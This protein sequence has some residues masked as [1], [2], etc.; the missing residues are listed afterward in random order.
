MRRNVKI[1]Y[2][3]LYQR[4]SELMNM[5]LYRANLITK[6]YSQIL[7]DKVKDGYNI[8]IPGLFDVVYIGK[9]VYISEVQTFTFEEQYKAVAKELNMDDIEVRKALTNYLKMIKDKLESGYQVNLKSI[10]YLKPSGDDYHV[11][12]SPVLER[13][14]VLFATTVGKD[15]TKGLSKLE[16]SDVYL[17]MVTNSSLRAPKERHTT[18]LRT[19]EI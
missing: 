3:E 18:E 19:I 12:L 17:K 16:Q 6:A 7:K 2:T 13:T 11:R 14:D 5:S 9:D 8:E 10:G 1:G 15:G 4:L